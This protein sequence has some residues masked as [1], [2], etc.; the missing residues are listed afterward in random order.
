MA[1]TMCSNVLKS[2]F[3]NASWKSHHFGGTGFISTA[4]RTMLQN[5]GQ[6]RRAYATSNSSFRNIYTKETPIPNSKLSLA[7]HFS[8]SFPPFKNQNTATEELIEAVRTGQA[9]RTKEALKMKANPN[10]KINDC[11]SILHLASATG[12]LEIVRSLLESGA[13]PDARHKDW[14]VTPLHKAAFE[15]HSP[16]VDLLLKAGANMK[17]KSHIGRF[18]L[19]EGIRHID[20]CHLL[21]KAGCQVN[22]VDGQ[23]WTPLMEACK[24]GNEDLVHLLLHAKADP[25]LGNGKWKPV[26]CALAF[27]KVLK[28]LLHNKAVVDHTTTPLDPYNSAGNTLLHAAAAW[29]MYES[30]ELLLQAGVKPGVQNKNL[31]TPIELAQRQKLAHQTNPNNPADITKQIIANLDICIT[32][33]DTAMRAAAPEKQSK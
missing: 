28:L 6:Q 30:V 29:G 26:A 8:T 14:E 16:I 27:P 21:L 25:N 19:D 2:I 31:L 1:I 18:P 15:G 32:L 7:R 17:I 22:Y 20:S 10:A 24:A 9:G 11:N 33:L 4:C 12:N 3:T 13:D 23:G 5:T